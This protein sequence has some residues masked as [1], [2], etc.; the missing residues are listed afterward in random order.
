[1]EVVIWRS[2]VSNSPAVWHFWPEGAPC[3]THVVRRVTTEDG[4]LVHWEGR[5]PSS[6]LTRRFRGPMAALRWARRRTLELAMEERND[7]IRG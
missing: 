7:V 4:R 3:A 5:H 1:M 2:R 6:G